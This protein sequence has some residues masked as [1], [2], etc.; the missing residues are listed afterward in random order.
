MAAST[1]ESAEAIKSRAVPL[2]P[3]GKLHNGCSDTLRPVGHS[4]AHPMAQAP[5]GAAPA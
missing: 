1:F 4:L 3:D 5:S 2:W